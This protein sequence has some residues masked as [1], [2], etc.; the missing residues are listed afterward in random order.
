MI[1][2]VIKRHVQHEEKISELIRELRAAA[3]P[4]P[5]YLGGETLVSTED[6]NAITVIGSWRS[7]IDWEN[8]KNSK[9]RVDIDRRIEPL[10][11]APATIEIYELIPAEELD[12][13]E[14]P[15]GFLSLMEHPSFDG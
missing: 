14:D 11:V 1:R 15:Y 5:G 10:L 4:H 3:M 9:K 8:W 6:S 7:I 2:V 13:L 12:F